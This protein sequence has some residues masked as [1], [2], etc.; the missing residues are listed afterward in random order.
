MLC[1]SG[2]VNDVTFSCNANGP[3]SSTTPCFLEFARW[4]HQGRSYCARLQTSYRPEEPIME[5]LYGA[6]DGVHAFCNNSAESEA[7]WMKL[8]AL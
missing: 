8:G 1:T 4:R 3:E 2:F 5:I 7:I 6:K